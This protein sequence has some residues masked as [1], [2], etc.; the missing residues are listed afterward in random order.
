M[1]GCCFISDQILFG[2]LKKAGKKKKVATSPSPPKKE[3]VLAGYSCRPHARR[4]V[5]CGNQVH[6]HWEKPDAID[7][8]G[9]S[10]KASHLRK[11]SSVL[12]GTVE[13]IRVV[14]SRA[15]CRR[16]RYLGQPWLLGGYA[17]IRGIVH[18]WESASPADTRTCIRVAC[19]TSCMFSF[20]HR[21]RRGSRAKRGERN[22]TP[23][24]ACCCFSTRSYFCGFKSCFKYHFVSIDSP[25][26][27]CDNTT[28][29]CPY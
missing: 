24:T 22:S 9:E 5:L 28:C 23:I 19:V 25:V 11:A 18:V 20:L 21:G 4:S 17:L 8:K 6:A 7:W 15:D 16:P 27:K 2:H 14:C 10:R 13:K 26:R 29:F 1:Y 12:N 3:T